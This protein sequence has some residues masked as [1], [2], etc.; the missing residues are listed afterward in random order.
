MPK[1]V[2]EWISTLDNR[3]TLICLDAH[4]QVVEE[5]E[6]FVLINGAFRQPPAHYSCRAIVDIRSVKYVELSRAD[7]RHLGARYVRADRQEGSR[8]VKLLKGRLGAEKYAK[9]YDRSLRASAPTPI[10]WLQSIKALEPRR[11][12]PL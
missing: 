9:L 10:R 11:R 1:V 2:R 12:V 7:V 4:G 6:L 5:D 8:G 3:T